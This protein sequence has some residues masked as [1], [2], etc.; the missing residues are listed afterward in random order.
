MSIET[1]LE[2]A[3]PVPPPAP[4]APPAQPEKVEAAPK[5]PWRGPTRYFADYFWFILKNV[6]GWTF[7]LASPVLGVTLPGPGGIPVFLIGFALVTFPGKRKITSRVM[8][9]RPL[10]LES[11]VFTIATATLSILITGGLVWF[12]SVQYNHLV[13]AFHVAPSV[14][15]VVALAGL[16]AIGFIVTWLVTRLM[17][18]IVNV[19]LRGMPRV[20]RYIRPWLRKYGINVLPSR[21]KRKPGVVAT[22]DAPAPMVADPDVI[23][24]ISE[25]QQ[26]RLREFWNWSKPWLRRALTVA[27]TVYIVVIMVRP[28]IV[29]WPV[30]R[31][32][33][34]QMDPFE[35]IGRFLVASAMFAIFLFT[36][37]AMVWRRILKG[38][39]YKLP[40]AAATRIWSSSE[41]ARYLPGSIWQVIGRVFL[42]RP[43]GVP[44]S[45]CSTSQILELCIFLLANVLLAVVCLLWYGQKIDAHARPY[46]I[47]AMALVPALGVVLH[48]RIFYWITNKILVRI[49]K[50]PITKR[51][52]GQ[53]LV[54]L[55]AW[56]LVG[57]LWQSLAVYVIT[58]KPLHLK[59]D[60]WWMVAGAYCL[61]WTAGFLAFLSPAGI[62]VR[63]LVFVYTMQLIIPHS[64][65]VANFPDEASLSALLVFLGFTLRI[66]TIVG[67]LMLT[68][69]AHIA[70]Y[71]G[72]LNRPDAPGRMPVASLS[73]N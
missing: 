28:L 59:I 35:L 32:E 56:T 15:L 42:T 7:I 3:K 10:R 25:T 19:V 12:F 21:R 16:C 27:L 64:V 62:G 65:K 54:G 70:D 39:G 9:G 67:E 36:F 37:R 31:E 5:H 17:L 4:P 52:R 11:A 69:I 50:A 60:W 73:A 68:L 72:T 26:T 61:A 33:L 51:L 41:L 48:P 40:Y 22:P 53:K 2:T 71:R 45:V 6:I 44:G 20:R 63:E 66:W 46:L 55:L 43:Y 18:Q 30:V 57:L 49:R 47:T 14:D 1:P 8:R 23:I 38:F 29:R 58:A 34:M 24:E 13:G